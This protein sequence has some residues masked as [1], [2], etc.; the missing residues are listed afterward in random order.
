[1]CGCMLKGDIMENTSPKIAFSLVCMTAL[2]VVGN[3]IGA[4]VLALPVDTGLSGFLP[5]LICMLI[6]GVAMFYSAVILVGEANKTHAETF[7]YP[8]LYHKYLGTSGKWIAIAANMIILYGLLTAYITGGTSIISNLFNVPQALHK[9]IA[10]VFFAVLVFIITMGIKIVVRFNVIFTTVMFISFF[11]ITA[12]GAEHIK[13]QNLAYKDWKFLP[14]AIPIVVTA[15]HFHNIIPTICSSLKWN[16]IAIIKAIAGGM[17]IGFIIYISWILVG[18]GALPIQDGEA[19]LI[20]AFDNNLP[21]TIPLSKMITSPVFILFAMIFSIVAITESCIAN[22]TGLLAFVEDLMVNHFKKTSR[23]LNTIIAFAPPLIVSLVYPDLFL[24]AVNV[25]G[26]FGIVL[27][28][29]ILPGV[30]AFR[31]ASG[32]RRVIAV[33]VLILFAFAF[34][35]EFMQETGMS[36]IRPEAEYHIQR[37]QK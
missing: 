12:M 31:N 4:G 3:L 9:W 25:A 33:I 27:L 8:S 16:A 11:T 2:L 35:F 29:G 14:C 20:Y 24:K 15:F 6:F 18:V 19:S 34:I 32:W 7:N 21:A 23:T 28:F 17:F 37:E 22:G 1:M 26:G 13:L 5:S 30:L 10:L 36:K